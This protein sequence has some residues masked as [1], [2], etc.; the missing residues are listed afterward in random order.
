MLYGVRPGLQR[1]IAAEGY[2]VLV[3]APFGPDWYPYLMRRLAER[4]ANL[5]VLPEEPRTE[6]SS[7]PAAADVVVVGGGVIGTSIVFHLAEA[8]VDVG[9]RRARPARGR[10]DEPCGRWYP[11]TVLRPAQHRDRL[12]QHRRLHPLRRASRCRDRSPPG[13]LPLPPRSPGGRRRLR[14]KRRAPERARRP[15]PVR[16]PRRGPRAVPARRARGGACGDV[17]PARRAREPRGGRPGIRSRRARARRVRRHRVRGDGGSRLD[18][19]A[20]SRGRDDARHDPRRGR[21]SAP[22]GVW[23]PELAALRRRRATACSRSC[24]RSAS[25]DRPRGSPLASRSP[26]TSRPAS[27]SIAKDRGSSSGWPIPSNRPGSTAPSDPAWLEKVIDVA[28]RRLPSLLDMGIAGGWKGY[29][30]VTPDHNCARRRVARRRSRF[31]YATGL[32]RATASCKA[33]PSA[34]SSATS[35][36][37]A[38]RSSTSRRSRS[39]AS[40]TPLRGPNTTSSSVSS[41]PDAIDTLVFIPAWNEEDN[42][43]A[44][45]DE[46]HAGLPARDVL[47]V[48]DGS[49]DGTA[50]VAR[51]HG[52]EVLSFGENRGLREGIAAGYAYADEHGY[53]FV[54]TRRRGRPA[55]GRRARA[56]ARDRPSGRGGRRRRLA[57]RDRRRL[58]GV[59]LRAVLA[60][61]GS[62]PRSFAAAMRATLGRPFL[63]ATSGMY[64]A[65]RHA[66]PA[67]G[68]PYTSGAPEVESLLRLRDAGLDVVEVPV[69]MRER[70]SGESKL[71]GSKAVKL[72]VTVAGHALAYGVWR[73]LRRRA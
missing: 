36:S 18:G 41:M 8:G 13:R 28:E 14:A 7:L 30:E 59:S 44:V 25:R 62:A 35:C 47:V 31:L 32:L 5:G 38:S 64:A 2:K 68:I 52:A 11:R 57:V 48:D 40:R 39:S 1:S 58:R 49:T 20:D 37:D 23:S 65:N 6:M 34:R 66:M 63:D 45:L 9:P 54:G 61:G 4:P 10:L 43:P 17:L 55:S 22:P 29:Y 69:H 26:S 56:A 33:R 19:G 50:A 21:S 12:A 51:A 53:E 27:T 42:L 67:L 70:A 3:A 72:V 71:R 15:E 73:R 60:A 46:L 16:R 24:A